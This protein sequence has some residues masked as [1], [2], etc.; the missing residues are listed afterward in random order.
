M[1]IFNF[2][3][4]EAEPKHPSRKHLTVTPKGLG[5]MIDTLVWAGL[6]PV[7]LAEVVARQANGQPACGTDNEFM[8]TFDDGFENFL[9]EAV[10]VLESRNCPG[11]VFVLAHRFSGTNAWDQGDLPEAERDQLMSE[12]QIAS[13]ADHAP[14]I[15]VG[16]HGL[17]HKRLSTLTQ[18][19]LQ[20]ELNA[21]YAIIKQVAGKAFVPV[22]AYPWGD[23][24]QG[25]LDEMVN[26]PYQLGLTTQKGVWTE[27]NSQY[28]I[29]RYSAYHRDASRLVWAAKLMRYGVGCFSLGRK[30]HYTAVTPVA[31]P[32]AH[33]ANGSSAITTHTTPELLAEE[34]PIGTETSNHIKLYPKPFISTHKETISQR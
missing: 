11:T 14:L 12:A 4:I 31:S 7:G 25:V 30:H 28:A 6:R 3:H 26:T 33:T 10:P 22:M 13:L 8:L 9:T 17:L 24:S 27:G 29:P 34:R 1:F 18:P 23:F 20:E 2:H 21:S 32:V 16:S 5:R 19:E 15:T